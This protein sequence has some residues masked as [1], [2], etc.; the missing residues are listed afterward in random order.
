MTDAFEELKLTAPQLVR[1]IDFKVS[2]NFD[3]KPGEIFRFSRTSVP[4]QIL[5]PLFWM[6]SLT[7]TGN[8]TIPFCN[9]YPQRL[10]QNSRC[11]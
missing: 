1:E 2:K 11:F 7:I 8:A 9:K 6:T 4:F 10:E 5:R 3:M